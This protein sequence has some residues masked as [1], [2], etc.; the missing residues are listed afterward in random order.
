MKAAQQD[1]ETNVH[2]SRTAVLWCVFG[3]LFWTAA[4]VVF[5]S[6]LIFSSVRNFQSNAFLKTEGQVTQSSFVE[7][8][9]DSDTGAVQE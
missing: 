4:T 1:A 8:S 5:Q 6:M 2:S 7:T 3:A 9:P